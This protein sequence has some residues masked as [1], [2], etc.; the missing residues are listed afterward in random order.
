MPVAM[1]V[2]LFGLVGAMALASLPL[3]PLA[4]QAKTTFARVEEYKTVEVLDLQRRTWR[5]V[6][7]VPVWA[8]ALTVAPSNDRLAFLSWSELEPTD[9]DTPARRSELVVIDTSGQVLPSRVK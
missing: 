4:A 6:F 5:Q 9:G 2:P 7:Q 8:S 1:T 3:A